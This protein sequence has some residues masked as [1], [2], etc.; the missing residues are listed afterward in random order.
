MA[1]AFAGRPVPGFGLGALPACAALPSGTSAASLVA[2]DW[3]AL[4]LAVLHTALRAGLVGAGLYAAGERAAVVKK[5]VAGSLAIEAF[6]L[7]WAA[8]RRRAAPT[9][10]PLQ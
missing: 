6:V 7:A 9:T 10:P 8:W 2:G 1:V 3:G 4:P 5:A